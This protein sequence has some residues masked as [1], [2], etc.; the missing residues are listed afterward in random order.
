MSNARNDNVLLQSRI[1]AAYGAAE[2]AAEGAYRHLPFYEYG[3]TASEDLGKDDA[4]QGDHFSGDITSGLVAVAGNLVVPTG[5]Q[6]IGWHLAMLFG[7]PVT[8]DNTGTYT[9]TFSPAAVPTNRFLTMCKSHRDINQHFVAD[10][11]VYTG[12]EISGKKDNQRARTTFM[13]TGRQEEKAGAARDTTPVAWAN[14]LVPVGFKGLVKIDGAPAAAITSLSGKMAMDA[15][16]DQE[17]M[18]GL[19]TA[20][21]VD[22]GEWQGD[23]SVGTRFRDSS[24]YDLAVD[25]TLVDL[26]L[27][28]TLSNGWSIVYKFFKARLERSSPNI[29]GRGILNADFNWQIGRPA[30]GQVPFNVVLTNDVAAYANPT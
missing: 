17:E 28:Y 24:F 6:S 25:G 15:E 9:H 5:L 23:G 30:P 29:S 3:I 18:N 12:L 16:A 21:G 20:A 19:P 8:V 27:E 2:A 26:S 10:S 4:I 1:Q 14:D 22:R 7:D 11:L 13:L